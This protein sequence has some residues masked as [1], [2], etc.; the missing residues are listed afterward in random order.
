MRS[1]CRRSNEPAAMDDDAYY[2]F[3]M[4]NPDKRFERTAQGEILIVPPAGGESDFRSLRSGTQLDRWAQRS[5]RGVAFGSSTE[6]ILPDGAALSP[7]AAWVSN[8]RLSNLTKEQRRKFMPVCPEFVI[9]VV[10][11]T[12]RLAALKR[13]M[14]QWIE[15]GAQL[16]W[17]IDGDRQTAHI[18]R[19]G[20]G[21][22]EVVK[23]AKKLH[24]EGAV[25]GLT[26][27]MLS[28]WAGLSDL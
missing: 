14:R 17:L 19:A 16:A 20:Q 21:E 8:G 5:R 18:Y 2:A 25:A 27:N 6:F 9:E 28:I 7:D 24:G 11:P 12:D 26:M 10:S 23:G 3:C 13:K 4:A 1:H 15:N 22:P